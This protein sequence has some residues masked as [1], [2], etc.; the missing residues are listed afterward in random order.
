MSMQAF[1]LAARSAGGFRQSRNSIFISTIIRR[2][3]AAGGFTAAIAC[4]D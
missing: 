1:T 2:V 4:G 3:H